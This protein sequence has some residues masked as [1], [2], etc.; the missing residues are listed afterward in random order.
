MLN[1]HDGDSLS[2]PDI[3][4]LAFSNSFPLPLESTGSDLYLNFI[5]NNV[6]V[7]TSH[8]FNLSFTASMLIL[9]VLMNIRSYI[10]T[11]IS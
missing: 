6:T 3:G 1:V 5:S 8:G 9:T 11:F 7:G 4:G 10:E 2:D